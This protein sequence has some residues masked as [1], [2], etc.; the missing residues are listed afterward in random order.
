MT[1][2]SV[3]IGLAHP[4]PMLARA[5]TPSTPKTP[6]TPTTPTC[7]QLFVEPRFSPMSPDSE[8]MMRKMNRARDRCLSKVAASLEAFLVSADVRGLPPTYEG[9]IKFLHPEN[10]QDPEHGGLDRRFL[11]PSCPH[12]MVRSGPRPR[13][14]SCA[15]AS[16][17]HVCAHDGRTLAPSART[18]HP[19]PTAL[20]PRLTTDG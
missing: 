10:V 6:T 8:D 14:R 17:R 3:G 11:L 7:P 4:R 20:G 2:S 9:W 1:G 13:P 12:R 16:I 19:R 5:T 15:P 18:D